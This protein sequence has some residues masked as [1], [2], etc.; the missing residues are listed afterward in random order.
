MTLGAFVPGDS[1]IETNGCELGL[2]LWYCGTACLIGVKLAIESIRYFIFRLNNED[3]PV[4]QVGGNYILMLILFLI[5]F[6]FT[7]KMSY[8]YRGAEN[9]EQTTNLIP[10]LTLND[11]NYQNICMGPDS[12][13]LSSAFYIGF[14]A[15][16]GLMSF[17]FEIYRKVDSG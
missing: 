15:I 8:Q 12:D 5:Y 7:Q 13:T 4:V 16:E 11:R 14:L 6:G 9:A 1:M 3:N 10:S 2:P 17:I